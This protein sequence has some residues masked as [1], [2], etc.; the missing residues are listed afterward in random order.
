MNIHDVTAFNFDNIYICD[1]LGEEIEKFDIDEQTN[2]YKGVTIL[3]IGIIDDIIVLIEVSND[4]NFFDDVHALIHELTHVYDFLN[5]ATY[6][7]NGVVK[8]FRNESQFKIYELYSEFHAFSLDE[9]YALKYSELITNKQILKEQFSN[10]DILMK[11]YIKQKTEKL[12]NTLFTD[13]DLFQVLAKFYLYDSYNQI[14]EFSR[15]CFFRY[16]PELFQSNK[17]YL[18]CDLYEIL[19][20]TIKNE[21]VFDYLDD[22]ERLVSQIC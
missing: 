19:Y 4:F 10:Q 6:Y 17:K 20:H 1:D 7:H 15:S 5:Y 3:P 11:N 2:N 13:Y 22:I 14:S 12:N 18:I 16:L 9:L 8:N 21:D